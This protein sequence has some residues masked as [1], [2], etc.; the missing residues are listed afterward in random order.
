MNSKESVSSGV[1]NENCTGRKVMG[2]EKSLNQEK[3]EGVELDEEKQESELE[4][5]L[6]DDQHCVYIS[7]GAKAHSRPPDSAPQHTS[8][9]FS[10]FDKTKPKKHE[11]PLSEVLRKYNILH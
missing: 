6:L 1:G 9:I 5:L 11:Y 4:R 2:E 7:S 10:P 3:I 8:I